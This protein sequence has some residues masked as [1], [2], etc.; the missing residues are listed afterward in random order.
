MFQPFSEHKH[1]GHQGCRPS[2]PF[3]WLP[4]ERNQAHFAR[5]GGRH[6][7][8]PFAQGFRGHSRERMFDGGELQLVLLDLLAAKP[9]YGYELIKALE[10]K[11]EGGYT[12]S[13]GVVYPTLT[14]L[15]E[16]GFATSTSEGGKKVFTVT[17]AGQAELVANKPRLDAIMDRLNRSGERFGRG[18]SP[19]LMSAMGNLRGAV[20]AKLARGTMTA[21]QL[22]KIAEA[23]DA[24]A[25]AIDA[26]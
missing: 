8:H 17:E 19:E 25:A 4:R 23:I 20:Q 1:H 26:V 16:K 14:M 6:G 12:P 2:G 9:S 21:E 5:F 7:E 15:E 11:L 22:R 3:S 10:E 13:P 18:R 24:A